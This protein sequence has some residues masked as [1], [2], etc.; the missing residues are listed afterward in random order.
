MDK[1]PKIRLFFREKDYG[2][3]GRQGL[4]KIPRWIIINMFGNFRL[5]ACSGDDAPAAAGFREMK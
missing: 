1:T 4:R 5:T 2:T 3:P